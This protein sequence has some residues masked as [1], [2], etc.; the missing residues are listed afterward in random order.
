MIAKGDGATPMRITEYGFA[1][2]GVREWVATP[3]CQAALI[4]ATTRELVLRKAEL[5]L[6]GDQPVP[7]ARRDRRPHDVV[8]ELRRACTYFDGTPKPSLAAYT[9]AVAGRPPPPGQTVP[10]ACPS[11]FQG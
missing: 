6:Q 3:T 4:Y 8:A 11:Q 10:L 2:G 9:E 1:T 7:V 5:G